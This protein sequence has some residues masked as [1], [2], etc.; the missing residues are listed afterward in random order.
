MVEFIANAHFERVSKYYK[1][2][3]QKWTDCYHSWTYVL[4][5]F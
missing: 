1:A 2:R 3:V 4:Y 5:V